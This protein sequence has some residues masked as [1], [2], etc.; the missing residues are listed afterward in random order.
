M[1]SKIKLM[2]KIINVDNHIMLQA[3]LFFVKAIP[4]ARRGASSFW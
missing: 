3:H 4:G 1:N 2:H